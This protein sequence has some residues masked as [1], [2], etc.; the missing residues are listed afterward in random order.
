MAQIEVPEKYAADLKELASRDDR[1]VEDVVGEAINSYILSR[2]YEPEL[3]AAQ[4]ERL[5]HSLAQADRGEFVPQEQVDAF[6]ESWEKD[7][8]SR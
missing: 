1:A 8:K 5:K 7:I 2:F 4:I 3:S 6:F